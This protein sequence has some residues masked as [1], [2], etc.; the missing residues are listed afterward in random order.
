MTFMTNV[1]K[2]FGEKFRSGLSLLNL[3]TVC[4]SDK[5]SSR[6]PREK[7]FPNLS[8]LTLTQNKLNF[9]FGN[10]LVINPSV[11]QPQPGQNRKTHQTQLRL[12]EVGRPV[13]SSI[14][15]QGRGGAESW[16]LSATSSPLQISGPPQS[17]PH[18]TR[19]HF[20]AKQ[21]HWS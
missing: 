12:G 20:N 21:G 10:F 1:C 9:I 18:S 11:L 13:S 16:T 15:E 6:L 4:T 17:K 7:I 3:K 14:S 19:G 8:T 5:P 2:Y